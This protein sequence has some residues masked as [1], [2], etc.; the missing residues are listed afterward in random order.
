ML[1]AMLSIL[2]AAML[3]AGVLAQLVVPTVDNIPQS[4]DKDGALLLQNYYRAQAHVPA[5]TWSKNLT[6]RAKIAADWIA[7]ADMPENPINFT[8][9]F[10]ENSSYALE[11]AYLDPGAPRLF[12]DFYE[13]ILAFWAHRLSYHCELIPDGGFYDY[14]AYTQMMWNSARFVGMAG[15]RNRENGTFVVAAYFPE[16]N[17]PG[18]KPFNCTSNNNTG[19]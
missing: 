6:D 12:G 16:G 4:D 5:L 9:R 13:A 2:S 19:I 3:A 1:S 11:V 7:G 17:I 18:Q 10:F 14:S 8:G 15:A